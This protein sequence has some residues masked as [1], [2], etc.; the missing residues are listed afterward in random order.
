MCRAQMSFGSAAMARS[1]P[2]PACWLRRSA[3]RDWIAGTA[4]GNPDRNGSSM[5]FAGVG[6]AEWKCRGGAPDGILQSR[7]GRPKPSRNYFLSRFPAWNL[8]FH[9]GP[10][11]RIADR[12]GR[13]GKSHL[14]DANLYPGA[15]AAKL[16]GRFS[17]GD[18]VSQSQYFWSSYDVGRGS[19]AISPD[20]DVS[21]PALRF[22]RACG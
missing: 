18:L 5:V 16:A 13:Y 12:A 6:S 20:A 8:Q 10:V 19:A 1:K 17:R 14:W 9:G 22:S 15:V 11:R 7:A 4:A 3:D 2:R 21:R